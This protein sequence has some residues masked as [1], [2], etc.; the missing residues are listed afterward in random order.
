MTGRR[1]NKS[2]RAECR[3]FELS[4]IGCFLSWV[5]TAIALAALASTLSITGCALTAGANRGDLASGLAI[6]TSSLPS[7]QLQS[8]Y[9]ASLTASGGK[10]PYTW[11]VTSGNLPSGLSLTSST[12]T[13]SG[14][15]QQAGTTTFTVAV[16][17]ASSPIAS[18]SA[19]M[20]ITIASSGKVQIATSSLSSGAVQ[21]SYSANLSASGGTTPYAW[22]IASGQLPAGLTLSSSGAITGIPTTAGQ[23]S[24][25]VQVKD[26]ASPAATA[27]AS[28]SITIA[29]TTNAL[30]VAT[31]SLPSGT[32]QTSYNANL[33][34]S[35]G[36]TPYAWSIASG[37]LPAGLT[38]S[39]SG[40]ITGIPTTAGQS[41]FTVQVKDSAS[42]AAT[43]Q[44][45]LS[46]N[47]A[48]GGSTALQISGAA[49]PSGVV[50]LAYSANLSASG[51]TAPYAWN[52]LSGQLPAGLALSSTGAITGTPTTAGQFTF[53]V[54]AT[55]SSSPAN[56]AN[57][58][59]GITISPSGGSAGPYTSRTDF[60]L[61]PLPVP[62]P[63]VGGSVGAGNCITEPGYNNLV[64]RATDINTLGAT[65]FATE[66][67]FTSCCGGWADLNAWNSNSTMFF[68]ST[69]GGGL[70]TMSFNPTTQATAP[71]YGQPL[72]G[73][74]GG[75]WSYSNPQLAYALANSPDPVIASLTFSSQTTPPQPVVIADLATAPNCLPVLMGTTG[76]KEL[77]VSRDEQT[78]VVGAGT[79]TQNS[80][81]YAIVYNRTKGCRWYNTQTGQIG[82]NWGPAGQATTT[83]LYTLHSVR[84]SGDGQTVFLGPAS[85]TNYRHFWNVNGLQ[86]NSAKNN[87]NYGHFAVGYSGMINT[88]NY[89]ADGV[90]CKLGMAYRTFGNLTNPTYVIP[91]VAQ[92]GDTEIYGDDH[93]SWNNN[94]TS[95]D[96]PFFTSTVTVP[97]GTAITSAWQNEILGFSIANP[98]TVWRFLSTYSTGTSQFFSC[99]IGVGTVSQ[100]GKWFS[101]TS[102]WGNTLGVDAAGNKRCDV[103]VGQLK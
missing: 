88:A 41:S 9:Q 25:T 53:A 97:Y 100:D 56:T 92:C 30:Q 69:G 89:T 90:W 57:Q 70:V 67:E 38:L 87:V 91:T 86:V 78:F 18:A 77:A 26:S 46:I 58:S 28:L 5:R 65:T 94:D 14:T 47:V 102:D 62:L 73:V 61:I 76:W 37:Q 16:H 75:W 52:V 79:G 49:L 8:G 82:G 17:D 59:F 21:T 13:I 6:K 45:S 51:G 101:F 72:S 84:I 27:Q 48:S 29:S 10:S 71:L 2:C 11:N 39:S 63:S 60:A 3:F 7:G 4:R 83:D 40:A 99:S 20:A 12:G 85:G 22:S 93:S 55:D 23:S 36:T 103:F 35:G 31:S 96:Q 1:L 42:P 64:C 33:S 98:G 19:S 68:V 50:G 74:R 43:A 34:A 32:V 66:Q 24:F 15:P 44:A 81:I 54:Q 80:A 95:D